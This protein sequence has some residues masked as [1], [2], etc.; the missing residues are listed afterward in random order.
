MLVLLTSPSAFFVNGNFVQPLVDALKQISAT[1]NPVAVVSNHDRPE[2][3]DACFSGSNVQ[4][5]RFEAR[6]NGVVIGLIATNLKLKS[7]DVV[8]LAA[9]D[10][11]LHMAKNG[12]AL[13]VAAGWCTNPKIT[14]LGIR[15]ANCA[16]LVEVFN[17]TAGWM[18]HWWFEGA[19]QL[20][21]VKALLDLSTYGR[22]IT[23]QI[24]G[25]K[26]TSVVKKGGSQLNALLTIAS[27]SLLLDGIGDLEKLFWAVY[28][29]SSSSNNGTDVLSDFTSRLR[30]SVSRVQFEKNSEPLFIR[31]T[32]ALKRSTNKAVDRFDCSDQIATIHLNPKYKK[33]IVGR[34]VIVVDDCTT[35]GLSFAVA[36]AFL[37]AAGANSVLGMAL[38]KFGNNIHSFDIKITSDPFQPVLAAGVISNGYTHLYGAS[39]N[40]TQDVLKNLIA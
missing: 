33:Q 8:V 34:N 9:S 37:R 35:Y 40:M 20:Y 29:S 19:N 15:V 23:Q 25:S 10:D 13:L 38:G 22:D 28:P 11:D 36:S 6:Q 14:R 7:Y 17:L 24:F 32:P 21:S 18:G 5:V 4:F 39:N 3:F 1:G 12:K 31:H 30:T 26:L 16:E 2:W 27:R